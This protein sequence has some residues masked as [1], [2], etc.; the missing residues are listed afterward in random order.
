[1]AGETQ[2][3]MRTGETDRKQKKKQQQHPFRGKKLD[4]TDCY[5]AKTCTSDEKGKKSI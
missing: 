1:M 3:L 4:G 5:L 2:N